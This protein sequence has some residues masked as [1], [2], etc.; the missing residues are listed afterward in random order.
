MLISL[1]ACDYLLE[2]LFK[3]ILFGLQNSATY[4]CDNYVAANTNDDDEN[5]LLQNM[6]SLLECLDSII[7]I[8]NLDNFTKISSN[9]KLDLN[10]FLNTIFIQLT[11][12][13]PILAI[14]MAKSIQML[15]LQQK[16]KP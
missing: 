10:K 14:K 4:L 6:I 11:D 8:R 5:I 1:S 13:Y 12:I 2:H 9:I 3:S 7:N 15:N 16:K